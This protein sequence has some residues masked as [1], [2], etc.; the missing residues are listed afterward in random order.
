M[1]HISEAVRCICAPNPSPLTH[2]GTNTFILGTGRVAVIDPGPA[3]PGH[4][5]AILG[6]LAL[7]ERVTAILVTHAHLD[8]SALARPLAE[9]TGAPVL[10]GG[11]ATEG[12]SAAMQALAA[13]GLAGGGEGLDIAFAPDETLADGAVVEG[14]DWRVEA[15]A[16]PGHLPTHLA[17]AFGT[18]VF[19][20]DH[21]MGWSTTFVSP[22]DGDM[23]AY[24]ASLRRLAGRKDRLFL[25]AHGP[26]IHDP[27]ARLDDLTRHR[28]M[29][30]A[31]IRE[32]L[33]DEPQ[34]AQALAR[35]IYTDTPATLLPAAA[36]NVLA[37]LVDLTQR[38]LAAHDGPLGETTGFTAAASH[39]TDPAPAP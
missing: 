15:L 26:A 37:H 11:R 24:M 7:G 4:L 19:T 35:R 21:V 6:A 5:D 22:P 23:S 39:A 25:P 33:G 29:R 8:H 17:F 27:A 16:T 20:G 31:A 14:P 36:R 32:A 30:E 38:K 12:R 1:D 13:S 3:S 2:R 9:A 28:R 10:A 34:T 18:T